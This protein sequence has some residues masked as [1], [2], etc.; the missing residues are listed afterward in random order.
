MFVTHRLEEAI[1]HLRPHDRAARRPA[2]RP[3]R[4]REG[5]PIA[6]PAII[7]KMV[8]RAASELYARPT[9]RHRRRRRPALGARPAH[10]ARSRGAARHR[11]R[12]RRPRS[13]GRRDPRRRRPRRLRPHRTRPRHLRRRPASPPAPSRSTARPIAPAS[14][15]DAIALGIG[16]VP[17]DRKHQA[18]FAALRH[19]ARISPSPRS[20]LY[21]A[22]AWASWRSGASAR[23][24]RD[25][26]KALSIRMASPEQA[27]RR[28]VGRQPAEGRPR[29]LAGAR[30]QGADRRRADA[31]RRRRRQGRGPP[32]PRAARRAR[33]RRHDDLVRAAR[34]ARGLRPHRHHARRAGSPARCRPSRPP[35][36]SSWR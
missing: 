16:L 8:G 25:Y 15:A 27:H 2:R 4:L 14:P 34:G 24:S 18:I 13:E 29:P 10:R 33:H 3:S 1:A 28:P 26:R 31:R 36:K 32:D 11:A 20:T 5:G 22:T 7:E 21:S 6:V 30:P 35:R 23:R 12:R 9:Q 19:P 17:E